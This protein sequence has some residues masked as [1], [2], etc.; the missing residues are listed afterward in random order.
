MLYATAGIT[1]SHVSRTIDGSWFEVGLRQNTYP[2]SVETGDDL[3]RQLFVKGMYTAGGEGEETR[4]YR[5][6]RRS[7]RVQNLLR[8]ELESKRHD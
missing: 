3:C 4:D 7:L 5:L 1:A 8:V 6:F 2:V